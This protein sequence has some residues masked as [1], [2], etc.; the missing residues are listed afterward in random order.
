MRITN[1]MSVNGYLRSLYNNNKRSYELGLQLAKNKRILRVSDDPIGVTRAIQARKDL[2]YKTQYQKNI[3]D[4]K[5]YLTQTES[6]L[7]QM[8]DIYHSLTE[9]TKSVS[10]DLYSE[11]EQ[12][13]VAM[14]AKNLQQ[15]FLSVANTTY[16]GKYIF[17]GYN[18]Y[19]SPFKVD[20]A[21]DLIYNGINL[22]TANYNDADVVK[23]RAQNISFEIEKGSVFGVTVNG[24]QLMGVGEENLYNVMS[25]FISDIENGD[26]DVEKAKE[27]SDKFKEGLDSVLDL[28]TECGAKSARLDLVNERYNDD[29]I[30][31][32]ELR[33]SVEDIDTAETITKWKVAQNSYDTALAVCAR[34]IQPSL[35]DFLK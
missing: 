11:D 18:T 10:T 30:N 9:L 32:E 12:R 27:Y 4:C 15:E 3:D 2:A 34:L 26:L 8:N 20:E 35:L 13:A 25:Q 31:L 24:V 14:Q 1:M 29:L 19:K 16:S 7:M 17:G 5:T 33:S 22:N 23:E 21:G 6:C 28:V